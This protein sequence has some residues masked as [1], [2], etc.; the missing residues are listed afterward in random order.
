MLYQMYAK[1]QTSEIFYNTWNTFEFYMLTGDFDF[2]P[3]IIVKKSK[4]PSI[5]IGHVNNI[6]TM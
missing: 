1:I 5:I 3:D 4:F 2:Y 6:P